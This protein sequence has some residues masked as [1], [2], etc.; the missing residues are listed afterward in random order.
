MRNK[1]RNMRN[2]F[3]FRNSDVIV[4]MLKNKYKSVKI[5]KMITFFKLDFF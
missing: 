4:K 1:L 3:F 5:K 2:N